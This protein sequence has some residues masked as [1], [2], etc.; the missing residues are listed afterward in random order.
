MSN[1]VVTAAEMLPIP[2][3]PIRMV[4]KV[5]RNAYHRGFTW[6]EYRGKVRADTHCNQ[7]GWGASWEEF[8]LSP[9]EVYLPLRLC[10]KCFPGAVE[11]PPLPETNDPYELLLRAAIAEQTTAAWLILSDWLEEQGDPSCEAIR[12]I[13]RNSPHA[14]PGHV[15]PPLVFYEHRDDIRQMRLVTRQKSLGMLKV[16]CIFWNDDDT[17]AVVIAPKVAP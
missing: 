15:L 7:S 6:G 17:H 10:R 16:R 11:K 5:G 14:D 4:K 13:C 2:K 9:Q 1:Y 8:I 3:R 12:F